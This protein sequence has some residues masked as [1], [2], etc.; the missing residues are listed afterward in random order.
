MALSAGIDQQ[1]VYALITRVAGQANVLTIPRLFI[2]W[3]GDHISALLL[4]QIIYW[5]SRTTDAE[6]WFYKSAK[7]WEE[8]LG[9]SDYQ[10]TR[11]TKKLADAGVTT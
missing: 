9:I 11:A 2:E 5:S 4:S 1:T 8:E 10:L 7:E 3:T 6:G